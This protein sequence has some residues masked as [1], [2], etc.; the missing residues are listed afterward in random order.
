VHPELNAPRLG[1]ARSRRRKII[2][3]IG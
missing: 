3:V 2:S 1:S